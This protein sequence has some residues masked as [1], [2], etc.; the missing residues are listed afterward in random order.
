MD[1]LYLDN[2]DEY[3]NDHNKIVTYKWLSL[4]LGVHVNTAK[5]MLFHYLDH[6]RKES[7]APLHAT[8]LVTGK[9]VENGN[10]SHKVTVVREEQLEDVKS[11]MSLTVSVH[12]YSVQKASLKDSGPLYS[13]D[14]DVVKDNLNSCSRY[15]AIKCADAVPFALGDTRPAGDSLQFPPPDPNQLRAPSFDG[16]G[17][18]TASKPAAKP[19]PKG[20][21]GMFASKA[22]PKKQEPAKEIKVEQKEDTTTADVSKSKSA[23]KGSTMSNFFGS[24][25]TKR[26]EK[27]VKEEETS[28]SS[29]K[30]KSESS[31]PA[32][33]LKE[34]PN[35]EKVKETQPKEVKVKETQPKEEKVNETQPKEVKVKETQ[36]KE[37]KVKETQ[38]K[39]VKVKETQPKEVRVKETQPKEAKVKVTKEAKVKE[40][41]PN[42]RSKSK[43]KEPSDSEEDKM[44]TKKRRRIKKPQSDS[45]DD[46][47]V[48]PDSPKQQEMR[49]PPPTPERLLKEK[50]V[51]QPNEC[52][53]RKRRRVMMSRTFM[54]E[55]GCIV[56]EKG[57]ESESYSDSEDHVPSAKASNVPARAA[58]G[59]REDEKKSKK[60]ISPPATKGTKQASIMGFFQK[61]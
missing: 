8:Y 40:A 14:Y 15:S 50:I 17:N 12:V 59:K 23:S 21:M 24:Q 45:S 57:Y 37:E 4:T 32:K 1:E 11:K 19:Q 36:P 13:V 39:E 18:Q 28:S 58:A 43:R 30:D 42:A 9:W 49:K 2:I 41:K 46:D 44:E 61:K 47:D 27:T 7:S 3:V 48:I 33:K 22:A 51:S 56:T 52:K 60:K 35:E 5:Q 34:T 29:V 26:A 20:I 55:E 25:A 16:P 6:K 10:T 54:D 38:P 31:P 53:R